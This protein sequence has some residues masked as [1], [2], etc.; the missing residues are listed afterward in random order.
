MAG[1]KEI[2]LL[3]VGHVLAGLV[4]EN[5]QRISVVL[6]GGVEMKKSDG[7]FDIEVMKEREWNSFGAAGEQQVIGHLV[8]L[9]SPGSHS[10]AREPRRSVFTV[11]VFKYFHYPIIIDS[12]HPVL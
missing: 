10:V 2:H 5:V 3:L 7:V 4:V 8:R 12:L 9:Y 6:L 11:A 1:R